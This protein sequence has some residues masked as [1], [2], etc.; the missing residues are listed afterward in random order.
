LH[1]DITY[2]SIDL[3]IGELLRSGRHLCNIDDTSAARGIATPRMQDEG[4]ARR[5]RED[6]K[7]KK[8]QRGKID[9]EMWATSCRKGQLR[10]QRIDRIALPRSY[11]S[12]HCRDVGAKRERDREERWRVYSI[13]SLLPLFPFAGYIFHWHDRWKKRRGKKKGKVRGRTR[14]ERRDI[15]KRRRHDGGEING[16]M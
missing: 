3:S 12:P 16:A 1:R 6:E 13:P 7:K 8:T 4:N 2:L 5:G 11:G 14:G 9:E 15:A 10:I